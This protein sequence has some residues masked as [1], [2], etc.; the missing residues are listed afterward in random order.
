VFDAC[1]VPLLEQDISGLRSM[2]AAWRAGGIVDLRDFLARHPAELREA[3]RSIRVVDANAA[4]CRLHE[5]RGKEQ[6][7]G[8]LGTGL[9]LH[10]EATLEGFARGI[11]AIAEGRQ[12]AGTASAAVTPAG[13]KLDVESRLHI[14]D[15]A[16]PFPNV[17]VALIDMSAHRRMERRLEHDRAMLQ[18][19]VD[20]IPDQVFLKDRTSTYLLANRALAQWAGVSAPADMVGKTDLDFF[21]RELAQHFR[22]DDRAI[23]E[24]GRG[25]ENIEEQIGVGEKRRRA[26]TTKVPFRDEKGNVAGIVGIVRDTE[27]LKR[28][29][30]ALRDSEQRFRA[31]VDGA[32]VGIFQTTATGKLLHANPA[33]TRMAGYDTTE[34]LVEAVNRSTVAEVLYVDPSQRATFVAAAMQDGQWHRHTARFRRRDGRIGI[35]ALTIRAVRGQGTGAPDLE[36]FVE[37]ITERT[38]AEEALANEHALLATLMD[39]VPD[40]IYFKDLDSRFIQVNRAHLALLGAGDRARVIGKT[41][42]DFFA[43]GHAEKARADERR[44]IATGEP[45]L[46]VTERLTWPGRPETWVSTTKLP[47]RDAHGTII[48]T[49]GISRDITER[50]RLQERSL[51]LAALVESSG[52]AIVG[53]DAERRVTSWNR[54]AERI[55]GY[56]AEEAIGLHADVFIPPEHREA[57]VELRDRIAHGEF[58]E[59][60][61]TVRRRRDG[62][63]IRVSLSLSPIR[64]PDGTIVGTASIAHDITAR[65]AL[66]ARARRAERLESLRILAGGVAHQFN[67][68][69]TMVRGY[70][71]ILAA[72]GGLSPEAASYVDHA[73]RAVQRAVDI[74]ERLQGL[75]GAAP[76]GDEGL[77]IAAQI[78]EVLRSFEQRIR[79]QD[80]QVVREYAA[81]PPVRLGS[82]QLCFLLSSLLSNALDAMLGAPRRLLTVR[83]GAGDAGVF[84]EVSDTG[85]GISPEGL[86]RLFSP[87]YTTKGEW[88]AAGSPLAAVHGVGLSLAVCQSIV[89]ESGGRIDV[90]GGSGTG[91]SFRVVLP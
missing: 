2:I 52:D 82:T 71:D 65:V 36:G 77:D 78:E 51:H 28:A 11:L 63:H 1:P 83:C 23:V 75:S 43:R 84:L 32:P 8:P 33:F 60:H 86:A 15:P 4:A 12:Y 37:D 41:D 31:I 74:T 56:T 34:Q 42:F 10:D 27:S 81:A 80:V 54:G 3:I 26:L 72:R 20:A 69:N 64:D 58:I 67:N 38:L 73:R 89:S 53:L 18:D 13:K 50:R 21:P 5:V 91:A 88:A 25:R 62:K 22:A 16:D 66:E 47:L 49:F 70:L 40:Y 48:G 35:F 57:A 29:E 45:L 30:E 46:D 61:Q 44:I 6:L 9:D 79:E 76:V 55:Y 7:L 90:D 24:S 59:N 87:F 19:L 85:C 39:T 68:I 17:I 14:P